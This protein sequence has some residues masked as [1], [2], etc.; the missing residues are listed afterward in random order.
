MTRFTAKSVCYLNKWQIY[1]SHF[2]AF[3]FLNSAFF[4]F[5]FDETI[6]R[7]YDACEPTKTNRD[8]SFKLHVENGTSTIDLFHPIFH[9]T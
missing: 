4:A 3:P 8:I 6:Y 7:Q 2:D 5:R 1:L 9:S